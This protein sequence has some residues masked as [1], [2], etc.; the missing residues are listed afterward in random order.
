MSFEEQYQDVLQNI[1]FGLVKAYRDHP[2]MTDYGALYVVETLVKV[3]NA[4][5]QGR[6][7]A[8]PQFQPHEQEAYDSVKALC[9]WRLG[10]TAF[11]S[12]GGEELRLSDDA[13]THDEIVACLKRVAKSIQGWTKRGGMR[14]YFDFVSKYVK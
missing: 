11:V 4:E 10:K 13:R 12:K 7:I 2:K 14:G 9:D 5:A 6:A 1:E 8:T 3:Y